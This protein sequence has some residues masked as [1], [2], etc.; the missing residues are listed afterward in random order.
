MKKPSNL[1]F[2]LFLFL[3]FQS[4]TSQRPNV[5]FQ[6]IGTRENINSEWYFSDST[7]IA[8]LI[9]LPHTPRI[10]PLVVNDQWQGEHSYSKKITF[11]SMHE[12]ETWMHFEGVMNDAEVYVNDNLAKKHQD[13]YLPFTV[14]LTP[15]LKLGSN[16]IRVDVSN[17]NNPEIPPGKPLEKLDF[18][19]YGGIYRDV[20]LIRKKDTYITDPFLTDSKEA[21]WL[22]HFDKVSP[23]NA[24]GNLR[25]QV[26]NVSPKKSK[27][28]IDL[29]L[30]KDDVKYSFHES[31][32]VES[33]NSTLVNIPISIPEPAL[34]STKSP[35][36]YD[37]QINVSSN[38][39][40]YDQ[41][42]HK[43]G[44]RKIELKNDGFFLNDE[45]LFL[46]GTNRHQE[47]PYIGYAISNNAN[48]RDALKIKNAGFD[49]VRLS[50]YPQDE[51]F[52]DACD[53][54]GILVMNAIPGWQFFRKGNFQSNSFQNIRDM[55]RRD[56]NHP[57]VVF[58][59]VS[60]NESKMTSEYM[61]E[62]N[63]IMKE[64]LPFDDIFTA[65]WKDHPAYDLFIPARQHGKYPHY[66]N[67]YKNGERKVFISEYGDWEYYAQNAGFNQSSFENLEAAER[68]SRQLREDGEHR[69]LQQAMNFQES[70]NSNRKGV[71]TIG[72]ANW[73][74][75]DYN[76]GYTDNIE[77]SGVSDIFRIPKFAYYFYKSQRPATE[78]IEHSLVEQGP[79]VKIASYWKEDSPKQIR[80]FSNCDKVGLYLNDSLIAI[81]PPSL[82]EFSDQLIHPPFEFT[83]DGFIPGKLK[84]IGYRNG[85][86]SAED[87]V[88]TPGEPSGL[89]ITIDTQ[90]SIMKEEED[91]FFVYAKV[92][93]AQGNWIPTAN[94]SVIFTLEGPGELVG[95]NPMQTEAG[96]A[97]ILFKGDH[98]KSK[99][100]AKTITGLKVIKDL[101]IK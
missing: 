81:Q 28:K 82:S 91:L 101:S 47:Y 58:W 8:E 27:V 6:S 80:V 98:V 44:I 26:R 20:W 72:H 77:A 88:F 41:V 10:E 25:I 14:N 5:S 9:N 83:I 3:V 4:C 32:E 40:L 59:E 35:S 37:M 89:S 52:L 18:N 38:G 66:W 55:A 97:T 36:Q 39:E 62:A 79:M 19:Y 92:L 31:V 33:G 87:S 29:L 71:G 96:I 15:L 67:N 99:I 60:L 61:V 100:S 49:F 21:G 86:V 76:R 63:R 50:H 30:V 73:L 90:G 43:V 94:E 46:R 12:G 57:S 45:K 1:F 65:G 53:E 22:L 75:F 2:G 70:A 93:D 84:A 68:S 78:T 48:F 42:N 17:K 85:I 64:E 95:A 16:E 7:E 51:S 13:G 74:M 69:L 34:W 11:K 56:R 54:L 23:D 24:E